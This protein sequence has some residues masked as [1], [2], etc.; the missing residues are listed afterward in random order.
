MDSS[1]V[2]AASE[3]EQK[4]AGE[5]REE[6][7]STSSGMLTPSGEK[8]RGLETVISRLEMLNVGKV[9]NLKTLDIPALLLTTLEE[10]NSGELRRFQSYPTSGRICGFPPIPESQ[11]KNT[12]RQ[13]TVNQMVKRYGPEG[14]VGIT[15]RILREM[16][17]DDLAENL[18]RDHTRGIPTVWYKSS[19]Q[20]RP[21]DSSIPPRFSSSSSF[22]LSGSSKE[23][24]LTT[25]SSGQ[26]S[27]QRS[28]MLDVPALLLTTLKELTEEQ[29]KIFQFYLCAAQVS[30]TS[31]RML[32]S[33]PIPESQLENTDRQVTV[34]Q[35]VKRYDPEEAVEITIWILREMDLD[36]LAEKLER[37]HTRAWLLNS[38]EEL[39]INELKTFQNYLTSGRLLGFPP[40]PKSQ[41]ENTDRQVIVDLMMNIY[42]PERAVEITLRI[43]RDMNDHDLTEKLQS[44]H[45]EPSGPEEAVEITPEILKKMNW[46]D[47]SKK[48]ERER[49]PED[50]NQ[51]DSGTYRLECPSAGLFQ[52]PSAGLFQC[53]SAGLFQCPSA[54]LF[55]CP[56]AGLFQC[57]SAGLFQCPSA[58][59]FQCPS[60]GLFQCRS[61]PVPQ[62]RSVPV[63]QCR[64]VPVP[65]CR[66][67][68]VPQCRSV[69]VPQ[70]RSV[71]VPQCR[72]VP[73]PQ[74]RWWM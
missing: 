33:P 16:D 63:P 26:L 54:G 56:S 53:P 34:D 60:A 23:L 61:V 24:S 66:S 64:S 57:P 41:L 3:K 65:Q 29:L 28:S 50:Y 59:L 1:K 8:R 14:A 55:Q 12:D 69:P 47:L 27:S 48:I 13:N 72:S 11:L 10:M 52:C 4:P 71:P 73:V 39:N 51:E 25:G 18:K 74:C 70:C 21:F 67:V 38:L 40:M 5:E 43:L 31:G 17:L 44:D 36:D 37:Y 68:P 2:V 42:G 45:T 46:D 7:S 49:F 58:G 9:G 62:C 30:F 6:T 35:M 22:L 20:P 32:G 15:L 19:V